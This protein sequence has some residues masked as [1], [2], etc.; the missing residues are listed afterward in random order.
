MVVMTRLNTAATT[1]RDGSDG[2]K[3]T[4]P[5]AKDRGEQVIE[6]NLSHKIRNSQSSQPRQKKKQECLG[7]VNVVGTSLE[8]D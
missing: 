7:P 3:E 1:V 6:D 2:R 8:T 5:L 4:C